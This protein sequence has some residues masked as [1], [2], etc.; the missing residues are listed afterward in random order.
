VSVFE[1]L[2][3]LLLGFQKFGVLGLKKGKISS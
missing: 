1:K 2:G 3:V